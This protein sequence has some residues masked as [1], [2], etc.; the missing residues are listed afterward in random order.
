MFDITINWKILLK[1][2]TVICA[3]VFAFYLANLSDKTTAAAIMGAV[4]GYVFKNGE[5]FVAVRRRGGS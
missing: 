1:I 3:T 2:V 5:D 4:I